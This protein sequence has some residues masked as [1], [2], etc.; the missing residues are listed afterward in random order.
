MWHMIISEFR[1][2]GLIEILLLLMDERMKISDITKR[3]PQQ[4][5]YRTIGILKELKLIIIER[6]PYNTKFYLL[7]PKGKKVATKLREIEEILNQD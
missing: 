3:I 5:T 7:T 1:Q 2:T 4:S 6:G